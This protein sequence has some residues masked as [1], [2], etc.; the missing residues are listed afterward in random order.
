MAQV[1]MDSK[2]YLE[3]IDKARQLDVLKSR[4]V[5]ELEITVD[6]TSTWHY[7]NV[8]FHPIIPQDTMDQIVELLTDTV[9][10]EPGAMAMLVDDN[11]HFL[12]MVSG[13]IGSHWDEKPENGE[14]DLLQN[15]QFRE[16][17]E[18]T[19]QEAK[20]QEDKKDEE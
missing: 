20:V 5:D 6:T 10:A 3:L 19:K 9:T 12:N 1:T 2:E 11:A 7:V 14:V 16:A 17:W 18:A 4:M 13:S 8:T 15:K